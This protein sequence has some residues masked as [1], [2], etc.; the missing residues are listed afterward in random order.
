PLG[1]GEHLLDL[2]LHVLL[3]LLEALDA[4]DER[5]QL[6]ASD[7]AD[8]GHV[9]AHSSWLN[10]CCGA[11]VR[12]PAVRVSP[13][14]RSAAAPLAGSRP[15]VLI[16]AGPPW[17]G[18]PRVPR[19]PAPWGRLA[20]RAEGAVPCAATSGPCT[21]S[22]RPRPTRRCA[23]PRCSSCARSA[24]ARARPRSTRRRSSGRSTR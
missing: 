23:R 12:D 16:R 1:F 3:L 11:G 17:Q 6:L 9:L 5:P 13:R 22:S 14:F 21:T 7:A 19:R 24:A 10:R 8:L 20:C 15:P 18:R 2:L 4:L